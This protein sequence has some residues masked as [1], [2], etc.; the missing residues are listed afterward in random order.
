MLRGEVVI[1]SAQGDY[2]KPRPTVVVQNSRLLDQ[3]DSVT[4]CF[5][6]SKHVPTRNLRVTVEP[7]AANGLRE[8]SQVQVEKIMTFPRS[9]VRGPIGRLGI[10]QMQDIDRYL[11]IFLDLLP[12][13]P[14]AHS[15]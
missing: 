5:L 7:D 8:R 3:L 13:V 11:M 1:V 12:P 9:K 15:T 4:V 2:G 14:I 10:D 6:T